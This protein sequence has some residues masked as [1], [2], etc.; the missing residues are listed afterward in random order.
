M[1]RYTVIVWWRCQ[2]VC[3]RKAPSPSST[4]SCNLNPGLHLQRRARHIQ[5][6]EA[7]WGR[8]V[9]VIRHDAMWLFKFFFNNNLKKKLTFALTLFSANNSLCNLSDFSS[10]QSACSCK[11][12][13]FRLTASSDVAPVIV[14]SK[15][16]IFSEKKGERSR[17]V[18]SDRTWSCR[19][20]SWLRCKLVRKLSGDSP[21]GGRRYPGSAVD[22]FFFFFL[23]L[24]LSKIILY[25]VEKSLGRNLR[26]LFHVAINEM[27]NNSML[28]ILTILLT[29]RSHWY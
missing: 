8:C 21:C 7:T 9:T 3:P 13:I 29:K 11:N 19:V 2:S 26:E 22:F 24:I 14:Y 12:L 18:I 25:R 16:I 5:K 10:A 20:T 4:K 17:N 28:H 1:F 15:T 27:A 23:E 6:G